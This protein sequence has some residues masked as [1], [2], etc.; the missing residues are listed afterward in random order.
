MRMKL[1]LAL[2]TIGCVMLLAGCDP[3]AAPPPASAQPPAEQ[4]HVM[5]PSWKEGEAQKADATQAQPAAM[6]P[7][8][9]P[10]APQPGDADY[11]K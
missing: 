3:Q 1:A 2:V 11:S 7:G 10:D 5:V 4:Q 9:T 8:S 6:A